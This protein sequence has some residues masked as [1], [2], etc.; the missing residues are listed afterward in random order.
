MF[1]TKNVLAFGANFTQ[2]SRGMATLKEIAL[3]LK[4]VKSIQK[5]TKSMKMVSAAK[6][7]RAERELR[8]GKGFVQS[9]QALTFQAD[10][11]VDSHN[12]R[13]LIIALSSDRGLCGGIH[14]SITKV[15]KPLLEA[16]KEAQLVVIGE[17]VRSQL[18]RSYGDRLFFSISD[19]GKRPPS[20]LEA[21]AIATKILN[22]SCEFSVGNIIFSK[23]ISALSYQPA[24]SPIYSHTAMSE[25]EKLIGYQC[26]EDTLQAYQEFHMALS[27]Y[28]AMVESS[29]S[30]QSARMNA[31]DNAT[32]NAGEMINKLSLSYNRTRQAVITNE[33][34]EIISGAAAV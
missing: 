34:I 29:A 32:K 13:K 3:R 15:V 17:K 16:D 23:F 6:Y 33:L 27:L 14:S 20:F 19:Y 11:Q 5:I 9:I 21:S 10:L 30:E 7:S 31:M 25:T 18:Q 28:H 26:E 24:S 8:N 4:S 12:K 2:Y 1:L 22:S